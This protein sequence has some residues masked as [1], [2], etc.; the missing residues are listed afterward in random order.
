MNKY[1]SFASGTVMDKKRVSED[2]MPGIPFQ[3][4]WAAESRITVPLQAVSGQ[5]QFGV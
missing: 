5:A 4:P 1:A 3:P 2:E